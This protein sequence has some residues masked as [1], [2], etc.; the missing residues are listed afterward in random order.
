MPAPWHIGLDF[1]GKGSMHGPDAERTTEP[2]MTPQVSEAAVRECLTGISD[3]LSDATAIAKAAVTCAQEGNP[4]AAVRI[5]LDVEQLIHE[6]NTLLNA[7]SLMN[8]LA[9][10]DPP[11]EET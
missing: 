9:P 6:A 11:G 7:A 2:T 1:L 5:A 8:R 3:R 10:P 4:D